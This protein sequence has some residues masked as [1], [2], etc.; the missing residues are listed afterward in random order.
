MVDESNGV[1]VYAYGEYD[2]NY[3]LIIFPELITTLFMGLRYIQ[4]A[5]G[6]DVDIEW[7]VYVGV[8]SSL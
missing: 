6:L 4:V 5:S 7:N 2:R 8:K 1:I 3:D